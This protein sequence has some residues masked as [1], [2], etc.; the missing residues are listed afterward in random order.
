M[1]F[2]SWID[3]VL[4]RAGRPPAV[5]KVET[6]AA[7]MI[8]SVVNPGITPNDGVL[9]ITDKIGNDYWQGSGVLIS[10]DEV[11]TASH[12][13]FH[14]GD[15]PA[16][17]IEVT[18]SANANEPATTTLAA[19]IHYFPIDDTGGDISLATSQTDYAVIH[20]AHPLYG[21]TIFNPISNFGG[22]LATVSGY[23]AVANGALVAY[24]GAFSVDPA[25]TLLDGTSI[26][27]GSSG[28]PV[29][30]E[31]ADGQQY[32]AGVVSSYDVDNPAYGN[33]VQIT[34]TVFNQIETW[35]AQDDGAAR[36]LDALDTSRNEAFDPQGTAYAGPVAG[37]AGQYI[38]ITADNINITANTPGWFLHSGSGEDALQAG[39]GTNV[40]DGGTGSNF[41]VGGSGTDTFFTD[42][43]GASAAIWDTLVDFHAGDAAT[44]FGVTQSGFSLSWVDGQGAA[45]YQG[46]TLH[47]SAPGHDEA[48]VTL[49][50]YTTAALHDG[51]L[52]LSFGTTNG[53]PYLYIHGNG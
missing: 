13:L 44:L 50:G 2:S 31:G 35:I 28:G 37:L 23:P 43:R 45:G 3:A 36:P 38:D 53:T 18:A 1:S 26:G 41:L 46:L 6:A 7:D 32:V 47:A 22:G 29:Y 52:S 33:D 42:D 19:N 21:R 48:S 25:Y 12:V 11:L 10:P 17:D 16:T 4:A 40:L 27:A 15:A 5:A 34:T 14:V 24:T 49:A 8:G 39:S 30:I 9:Y 51:Q 20:L